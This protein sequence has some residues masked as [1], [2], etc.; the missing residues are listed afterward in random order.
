MV[1][2]WTCGTCGEESTDCY[3]CTE[4]GADMAGEEKSTAGRD[5]R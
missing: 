5:E 2:T 3:R 1:R 4:C